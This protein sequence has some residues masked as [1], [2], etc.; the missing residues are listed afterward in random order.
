MTLCHVHGETPS[1]GG[2]GDGLRIPSLGFSDSLP[3]I[4]KVSCLGKSVKD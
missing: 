4:L 3:F 1:G 2:L